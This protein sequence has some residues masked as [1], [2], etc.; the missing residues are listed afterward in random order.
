MTTSAVRT[1]EGSTPT[2][3]PVDVAAAMVPSLRRRAHGIDESASFPA[4]SLTDLRQNGLL[5]LL[6]PVEFGGFGGS[7]QDFVA[8]AQTIA[9]GC[10][11]TAMVWTMHSQQVDALVR[12]APAHLRESLLPRIAA[13]EIYLGSVTSEREKG[14]HILTNAAPLQRRGEDLWVERDAPVVTGGAFAD[15]F[16]ATMRADEDAPTSRVTLVYLERG[17]IEVEARGEW[18]PL[19]MRGT[20]S[21][22]VKLTGTAPHGNIIGQPGQFR[23]IAVNSYAPLA[24]I[25]W[26]ACWLGTARSALSDVVSLLRSAQCPSSVN[27]RSEVVGN[28]LARVRID[29]ELVSGYL[30]SALQEVERARSQNRSLDDPAMQIHLNTLKIVAAELTFGAVDQ[31]L[32]LTGLGIGYRKD[33]PVP[34][35]RH[36][37]DLRSAALNYSNDR[38]L[39][40]NGVLA[41]LDPSVTLL[42]R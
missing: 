39:A 24:H 13:G 31:L 14:G 2:G 22:A 10:L 9:A 18:N 34:L 41:F 20:S 29:L 40:A 23:E 17:P 19:G 6:V 11:S 4:E 38:L 42:G 25:G 8:V 32:Q 26:S 27:P 7:L 37:R 1:N 30:H 5:G 21:A 3:S 28:R 36:F 33:S 35:E 12:Y 15:G 16:L